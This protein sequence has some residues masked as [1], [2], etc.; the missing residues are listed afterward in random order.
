MTVSPSSHS[1]AISVTLLG[2]GKMGS[3]MLRM[4]QEQ[5]LLS[6]AHVIKPSPLPEIFAHSLNISYSPS[7]DG[8]VPI[9]SDVFIIAV[10]PQMLEDAAAPIVGNLPETC[11]VVSIAAGK[12]LSSF[13]NLFGNNH[14]VVR[15][16]PN[17]PS[18]IGKGV[19]AAIAN[20]ATTQKQRKKVGILLEAL[21]DLHWIDDESCMNAVSALSGS[22]PA[23]V[24]Y[25]IEVLSKAGQD[26]G[27]PV[28]LA[29]KLARQTVI[30][31]SALAEADSDVP[32]CILRENVTSPG[33]S[34]LEALKI[35]MDGRL[36]SLFCD[37][38]EAAR[39]RGE[40]LSK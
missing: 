18:A 33:G 12:E 8:N 16:M 1:N 29:E 31:S 37:A 35:L 19:S 4:W 9:N 23:Y 14:P 3:A 2:C 27:L 10:K 24:F 5:D 7:Y 28:D 21:G 17:T 34:T 20:D 32:A 25:L 15:V 40:E 38:L 39:K 30:G 6:H 26:I 22:G 11:C 13:T 36:E